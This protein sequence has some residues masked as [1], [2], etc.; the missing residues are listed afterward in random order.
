LAYVIACFAAVTAFGI[1]LDKVPDVH[2]VG[3]PGL[4]G[5]DIID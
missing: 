1:T 3:H 4:S 2:L 5:V